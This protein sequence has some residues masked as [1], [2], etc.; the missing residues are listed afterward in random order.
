[1]MDKT[2]LERSKS[3]AEKHKVKAQDETNIKP[4]ILRHATEPVRSR[5]PKDSSEENLR[6]RY[7]RPVERR[8]KNID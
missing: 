5:K 7:I 1:M 4:G 8:L 6:H 2:S 3:K